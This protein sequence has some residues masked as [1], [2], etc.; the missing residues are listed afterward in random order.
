LDPRR[1]RHGQTQTS[2][3]G[4]ADLIAAHS[5]PRISLADNA[6]RDLRRQKKSVRERSWRIELVTDK[7]EA[8]A[9][10]AETARL[11]GRSFLGVAGL[12]CH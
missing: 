4:G 10:S 3:S 7:Y 5:L 8:S 9:A 6:C 1:T 12:I 2:G 11:P